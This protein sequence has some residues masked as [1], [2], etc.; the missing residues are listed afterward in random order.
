MAPCVSVGQLPRVGPWKAEHATPG[1]GCHI[2]RNL[3]WG[4]D[5]GG[6]SQG[7]VKEAQAISSL[8]AT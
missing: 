8:M 5:D 3:H 7:E 4:D 6:K 2:H 1:H